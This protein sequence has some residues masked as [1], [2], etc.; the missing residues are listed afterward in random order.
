MTS[1]NVVGSETTPRL[2]LL[3]IKNM[4]LFPLGLAYYATSS[5]FWSSEDNFFCTLKGNFCAYAQLFSHLL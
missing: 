2:L 3:C 4:G 1:P 5:H